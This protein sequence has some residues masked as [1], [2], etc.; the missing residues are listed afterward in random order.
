M[1]ATPATAGSDAASPPVLSHGADGIFH[2]V[3]NQP[4][5]GNVLSLPV[6][7]ALGQCVG[8][9]LAQRPRAIVLSANGPL[10]CGGGD[11]QEFAGGA[12][13]LPDLLGQL[14]DAGE[15]VIFGLASA[16]CPVVSV[17]DG[18]I[19]G[20]GIGL[21]L[22]ADF[23]LASPRM[24]LRAGYGALGLSPDLGTSWHLCRRVGPAVAGRWL[25]LGDTVSAE[26][27]LARGAIDLLVPQENLQAEAARLAGRLAEGSPGAQAAVK[28]LCRD[29]GGQDLQAQYA[30]E[31]R[32]MLENGAGGD[33]REGLAA[34]LE[35]RKP[36]YRGAR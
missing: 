30:Q 23:V 15:P 19:A 28:R 12:A 3:L 7:R 32:L 5:R 31:R 18:A 27:C 24:K 33:V 11:I 20:A 22:G 2:I 34:F 25:L 8:D 29:A 17:L 1:A 36:H 26:E 16:P 35:K 4:G 6:L 21:A 13:P 10:F 14:L 9:V